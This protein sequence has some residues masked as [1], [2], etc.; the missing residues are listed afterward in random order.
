M[1]DYEKSFFNDNK[2]INLFSVKCDRVFINFVKLESKN[3]MMHQSKDSVF[4]SIIMPSF[5]AWG[6]VA[7]EL[8]GTRH[9]V[10]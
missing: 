4:S 8:S 7:S 9:S 2:C 10:S 5:I 1:I 6:G 3:E